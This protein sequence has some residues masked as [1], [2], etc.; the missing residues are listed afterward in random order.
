[1]SF[2]NHPSF[3]RTV[4]LTD[5]ATCAASGLLMTLAAEPL[6]RLTGIPGGLP[7]SAGLSLFPIAAFIAAVAL[8]VPTWSAGVWLVVLGN[9]SWVL[10]SVWMLIG[11]VF[12]PNAMGYAFV[13]GQAAIVALLAQ[14][15]VIG[16]W[17]TPAAGECRLEI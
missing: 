2:T 9:V 13:I 11:N 4:L 17:R 1:M 6:A 8:R 5:A 7:L 3:L 14:L 10:G 12:T 15:E 16:L